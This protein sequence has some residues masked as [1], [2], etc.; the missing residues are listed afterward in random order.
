MIIGERMA[1]ATWNNIVIAES[2]KT[3]IVEGNLYFPPDSTNSQYLEKSSS[4][5]TCPWKGE[6]SYFDIIVNNKINKDS[7]WYYHEPKEA[8]KEIKN[9]VAFWKEVKVES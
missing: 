3:I 8:A 6:A 5:S 9:Y 4:H 7:A 1:R 2:D